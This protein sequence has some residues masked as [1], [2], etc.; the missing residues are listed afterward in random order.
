MFIGH[1]DAGE[2]SSI[3]YMILQ[4]CKRH[5]INPRDYLHDVLSRIPAMT[6]R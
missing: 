4:S 2:R 5:G 6:N 1:A 3:I